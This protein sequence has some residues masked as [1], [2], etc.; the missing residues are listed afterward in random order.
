ICNGDQAA[1]LFVFGDS[2]ID[3]GNYNP[4]MNK[5][6]VSAWKY[7]Y[8]IT[9]PG[10]PSGRVSSGR[11]LTDYTAQI[12]GLPSPVPYRLLNSSTHH[13][14]AWEGINFAVAY[15]GVFDTFGVPKLSIQV[16]Q[17]KDSITS[18]K[19]DS[20]H[21]KQSIALLSLNGNDYSATNVTA[22]G[23]EKFVKSVIAEMEL[24]LRELYKI[25][26]RNFMVSN[27]L[28]F[29]CQPGYLQSGAVCFNTTMDL[30]S[31]HNNYLSQAI[32]ELS[33]LQD[34]NFLI[35]DFFAAFSHVISNPY[36][37]GIHSM[38]KSCCSSPGNM[39]SSIVGCA[40]YDEQG[41][42]QYR[43]CKSPEE[44]FF[45][46]WYHPT[47]K[48]WQVMINLFYYQCG[49]VQDSCSSSPQSLAKWLSHR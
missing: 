34:A 1:A 35:L 36:A 40:D 41:R 27:N 6:I 22:V 46:D 28:P 30:V 25:G 16:G 14:V 10:H 19:Y 45:F 18:Q 23:L 12:L 32:S 37:Y 33:N 21:L 15:S 47:Q 17:F 9:W 49:F 13:M 26:I 24:Q 48:G 2:Y 20:H 43:L 29:D 11:L 38:S 44:F 8:G 42:A 5:N 39:S 4:P 31:T 7:P 3:T